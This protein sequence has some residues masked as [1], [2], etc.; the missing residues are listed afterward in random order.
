M[1]PTPVIRSCSS[2]S[3]L[4]RRNDEEI[5]G[6]PRL[7]CPP[8]PRGRP[9]N[10]VG[11]KRWFGP[12][13][14]D[15]TTRKKPKKPRAEPAPSRTPDQRFT[16]QGSGVARPRG[17]SRPRPQPRRGIRHP[18]LDSQTR[19]FTMTCQA[20]F[21]RAPDATA[22][23]HVPELLGVVGR[24]MQHA[25]ALRKACASGSKTRATM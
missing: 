3:S 6:S 9:E 8:A 10:D 7:S 2:R 17:D 16:L 23:P 21:K 4:R 19:R 15:L 5:V 14:S 13:S 18:S 24:S 1:F 12:V 11:A 20:T 22:W 25:R